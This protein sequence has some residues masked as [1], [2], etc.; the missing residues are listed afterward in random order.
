MDYKLIDNRTYNQYEFRIG[1]QVAKIEYIK[2]Q[3]QI[4]LTHTEVPIQLEGKGIGSILVKYV[5]E[6]IKE[7]NL[8]L[9]PLCPFVAMYIKEHPVWKDLVMKGIKIS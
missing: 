1:G 4:Y 8:N 6:D 3:K 2:A 5:L 9:I 7:N